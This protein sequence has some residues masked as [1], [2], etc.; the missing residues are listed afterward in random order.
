MNV[1]LFRDDD[2]LVAQCLEHD[3]AAQGRTFKEVRGLFV[4][5]LVAEIVGAIR[6]GRRPLADIGPAPREFWHLLEKRGE[7]LRDPVPV[8]SAVRR[9]MRRKL[10]PGSRIPEH[11]QLAIAV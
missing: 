3:I 4:A 9:A 5:T 2:Y 7:F 10:P 1:V 8:A 6:E 11:A